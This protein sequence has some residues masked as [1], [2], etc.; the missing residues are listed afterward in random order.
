MDPE[1]LWPEICSRGVDDEQFRLVLG[2]QTL[3]YIFMNKCNT[4]R[5]NEI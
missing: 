1:N 3:P 2:Y 4:M 5:K